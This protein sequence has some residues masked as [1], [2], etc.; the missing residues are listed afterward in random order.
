MNYVETRSKTPKVPKTLTREKVVK[1]N[2]LRRYDLATKYGFN[3][4]SELVDF[5]TRREKRAKKN[6]TRNRRTA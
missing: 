2:Y 6:T 3:Y 1:S 5:L 4:A